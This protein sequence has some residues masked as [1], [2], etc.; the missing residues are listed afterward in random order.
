[1]FP[2]INGTLIGNDLSQI[3]VYAN[4]ITHGLT[5]LFMVF[6]F[7]LIV[8]ITSLIMQQRFSGNIRPETSF[9]AASF[10]TLGLATLLEQRTGLLNPLYFVIIIAMTV[11]SVIWLIMNSD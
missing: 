11:L 5:V 9:A 8:L 3:F 10:A 1:M 7:F 2:A 4:S 6:G